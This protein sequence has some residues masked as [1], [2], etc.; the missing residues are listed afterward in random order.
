METLLCTTAHI[1]RPPPAFRMQATP[2]YVGVYESALGLQVL[3]RT[4][5]LGAAIAILCDSFEGLTMK[6]PVETK[7]AL[8]G[9]V[10]G[11][12]LATIV[13]FT[14]GGWVTG[15]RAE[16]DATQRADAA[17]VL[18]L[19]PVCVERFER[20]PDVPGHLAALKKVDSW[21]QADFVEK[22]GWAT[23]PGSKETGQVAAVAKACASLLAPA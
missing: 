18:A 10:G 23:T 15:G 7:P 17:V 9:V 3:P 13:G 1:Q 14:W 22:G 4:Y 8:W 11:A 21:S 19:A 6:I 12:I 5:G 2:G 20:G 16:A